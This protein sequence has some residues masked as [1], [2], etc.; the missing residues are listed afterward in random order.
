MGG[1]FLDRDG[2]GVDDR[3]QMG[4]GQRPQPGGFTYPGQAQP[5]Q[6]PYGSSTPYAP[7]SRPS[8]RPPPTAEQFRQDRQEQKQKQF[9]NDLYSR[10]N[11]QAGASQDELMLGLINSSRGGAA[12]SREN[13]ANLPESMRDA[14]SLYSDLAVNLQGS[15]N[16]PL[17][18]EYAGALQ[19][20]KDR[21]SERTQAARSLQ[22][23]YGMSPEDAAAWVDREMPLPTSEQVYGGLRQRSDE[24]KAKERQASL[25]RRAR[26]EMEAAKPKAPSATD[27][28][29]KIRM[30]TNT[31]TKP[32][33]PAH[34]RVYDAMVAEQWK[35][36][37][38]DDSW[39]ATGSPL[40]NMARAGNAKTGQ[41]ITGMEPRQR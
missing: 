25:D 21:L 3:W 24:A 11:V 18:Q 31:Q 12:V 40:A 5:A 41:G 32:L 20:F 28:W 35:S 30:T 15:G 16:N 10:A 19:Q 27:Q 38:R 23:E 26:Q 17:R 14:M 13:I 6:D 33:S 9:M 7:V 29:N 22:G 4:P 34:Q 39:A 1:G 2:D 8:N 36:R 37:G